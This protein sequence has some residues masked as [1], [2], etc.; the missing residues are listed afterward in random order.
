MDLVTL[1]DVRALI[2]RLPKET[3][4]K[5]TWQVA[6]ATR[7]PKLHRDIASNTNRR[8]PGP[9]LNGAPPL[10][11]WFDALRSEKGLCCS[12][13]DGLAIADV[14]W[15]TKR[16]GQQVQYRARVDGEWIDIPDAAVIAEPNKYGRT[17]I[18][19]YKDLDGKTQ[20]RCFLP[21]AEM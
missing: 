19:P 15:D 8:V 14:D 7:A 2:G 11:P 12:F 13:A 21:G 10:K 20:V 1:A 16:E 5:S 17:V 4:A 18:W 6:D 9:L 3:R